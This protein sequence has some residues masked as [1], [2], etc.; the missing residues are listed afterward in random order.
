MWKNKTPRLLHQ[1]SLPPSLL[2][3]DQVQQPSQ[4]LSVLKEMALLD[5]PTHPATALWSCRPRP[6]QSTKMPKKEWPGG[7][8]GR[9]GGKS[10]RQE[11]LRSTG[12]AWTISFG[13][14]FMSLFSRLIS[15][16]RAVLPA[17]MW[18]AKQTSANSFSKLTRLPC[19]KSVCVV[20]Q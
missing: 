14:R 10:R 6:Q 5:P 2:S 8:R 17:E 18:S 4:W 20:Q 7:Q 12:G 15:A 19:W 3:P 9:Q 16:R 11:A 13:L 1:V